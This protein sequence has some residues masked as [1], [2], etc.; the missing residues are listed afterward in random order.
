MI[1]MF[2]LLNIFWIVHFGS[3]PVRTLSTD[4]L[5]PM[6]SEEPLI[7]DPQDELDH[8]DDGPVLF[9]FFSANTI[10]QNFFK[11]IHSINQVFIDF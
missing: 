2:L 11:K 8:P 1:L 6:G 7:Y 3:A 9:S 5:V 10:F 4:N